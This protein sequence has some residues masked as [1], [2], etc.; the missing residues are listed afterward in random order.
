MKKIPLYKFYRNKTTLIITCD[1]GRGDGSVSIGD[2]R[3]HGYGLPSSKETWLMAL[4]KNIPAKGEV[5]DSTVYYNKQIAPTV[6]K[7]LGID[8]HPDHEGAG[9]PIDF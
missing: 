4:G 3:S 5:K 9:T 6:A 2:W 1:H 7:I 8:F